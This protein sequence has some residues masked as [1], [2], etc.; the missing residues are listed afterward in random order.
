[1]AKLCALCGDVDIWDAERTIDEAEKTLTVLSDA[2][3]TIKKADVTVLGGAD[4]TLVD[5]FQNWA[6]KEMAP[7]RD[8]LSAMKVEQRALAHATK[9]LCEST[10][11]RR[12]SV[13]E[14]WCQANISWRNGP[15][16]LS[17]LKAE[18]SETCSL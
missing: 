10:S 8:L 13:T 9:A 18:R 4:T 16:I 2:I 14:T 1:M 3:E 6:T 17:S 7:H 12:G 11:G 5:E 15:K